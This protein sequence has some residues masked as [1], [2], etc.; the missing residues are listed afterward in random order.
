MSANAKADDAKLLEKL[1]VLRKK[2][3]LTLPPTPFLKTEIVG[4][5]G[6]LQPFSFRYY[7]II[8]ILHMLSLRRMI[9]GDATGCGKTL[10]AIGTLCYLWEKKPETK[11]LVFA[12]KSAIRQWAG[13]IERFTNGIKVF[14]P[15]VSGGV[16]AR[17]KVYEEWLAADKGVLI[18]NYALLVRDWNH[19]CY[20]PLLP[21]GRPDPKQPV[22]P[23]LFDAT[24]MKVAKDLTVIFDECF[25]YYT[26]VTL[27]DGSTEIIG[28]VV[29]GKLPVRVLTWNHRHHRVEAKQVVNW[30]RN[31]V[32]GG[33]GGRGE[34]ESLLKL[35]FK[36]ARS[37]RVT[38]SHVFYRPNG[39]KVKATDLKVGSKTSVLC[40]DTPSKD[41]VQI[42]LGGL[43]GDASVSS[44]KRTLWGV[45]FI[46]GSA[47]IPYL[48]FKRD[49]LE[50]LGVSPISVGRSGYSASS[51]VHRFTLQSNVA[52]CSTFSF[53]DGV[54]KRLTPSWLNAIEPLGLAIWYADDGSLQE[55][56]C[57]DGSVSKR[58]YLH[59]QGFTLEEQYL[60]IG[61]LQWKWGVAAHLKSSSKGYYLELIAED[62]ERF[63]RLLPAGFPGVEYKFPNKPIYT[64]AGIDS[65][66]TQTIV[67][68]EVLSS[69]NWERS[70]DPETA[71]VYDIEVEGNHNYFAGGTLVS[72]CTAFKS[73]QTKT[74]EVARFLSDRSNRVYGLTA[75]LL[76]NNLMEGYSIYKAIHPSLFSTK[77]KFYEDYCYIEYQRVGKG[78]KI[79]IIKGYKNLDKFREVI[80]PVFLGRQ[81]HEISSELPTLTTKEVTFELD[82][83]EELKYRE[84]LA[85]LLELGDGDVRE[86]EETKALTSLIYCQQVVNSLALLK[87]KEGD[88]VNEWDSPEGH[89]IK[90]LNSKEQALVDLLTEELDGEKVIVYT[91][92]ESHVARLQNILKKQKIKSARITGK[93]NDEVRRASQQ[94]FQD[95]KSDTRV[96]FITAAGSEA[97]NL[98]AA[99]GLVF[100][101]MPWSWGDYIQ[102]LGRMIRIGSPHLA[103]LCFHLLAER[104]GTGKDRKTI[105]HHVLGMLRK[106]KNVIDQVLGEAAV[107]AL[108]FEKG[109]SSLKD[110]VRAM[111]GTAIASTSAGKTTEALR[112]KHLE[113]ERKLMNDAFDKDSK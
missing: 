102:I 74:W 89:K 58:I 95:L 81:K 12:P 25:D 38:R 10:E 64:S 82:K 36:Y 113:K 28:K 22:V 105:D 84:A 24:T 30:F 93:E 78:A 99:A 69:M 61:W 65:R 23:G 44:P 11:V 52:L 33:T 71:F 42:V 20:R 8:G 104:P 72:N 92:F 98:Q 76:K 63:F 55:H 7:Q 2:T 46:Q 3:D 14:L 67:E 108:K 21:N 18:L 1:R 97:I 51:K 4:F 59:T 53:H 31:P 37:C 107:G 83:A 34:R 9:L 29:S 73:M 41:Q 45:A 40:L 17:Q 80:E 5:D 110:L 56:T 57:K 6:K 91:R 85:G 16:E 87:F 62:A 112:L 96:V 101:D 66:T 106:K 48:E 94:A 13:E 90:E 35:D 54:R 39:E 19:G 79:P 103:V 32:K 26:P 70:R 60:L 111:Q 109:E 86:F 49:A 77:T 75:T 47:Q 100:F 68:D 88:S 27:E 15:P 43:L 50:S